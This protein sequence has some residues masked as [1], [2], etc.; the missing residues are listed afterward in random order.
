M[1]KFVALLCLALSLAGCASYSAVEPQNRHHDPR[2]ARIYFI[3]QAGLLSGLFEYSVLVDGKLIGS[4]GSGS[5]LAVDRPAGPR[6]ITLQ[7]AA[8][9][10]RSVMMHEA[11]IPTDAGKSY[12]FEIGQTPRTNIDVMSGMM[13]GSFLGK[14]LQK[15]RAPGHVMFFELEDK[16]G[17]WYIDRMKP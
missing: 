2:Q 17:A 11:E 3:R 1:Q 4:L 16:A 14:P 15:G 6:V 7:Q 5:F 8:L 9:G 10:G 12:Y 13:L